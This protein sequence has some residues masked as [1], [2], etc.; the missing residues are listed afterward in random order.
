MDI[1]RAWCGVHLG[2]TPVEASPPGRNSHG[3]CTD[4]SSS[5][6][7][8]TRTPV[9]EFLRGL[10]VPVLLVG[11]NVEVL[12]ANQAAL[13]VLGKAVDAVTGRLGG[14]VFE[15]DN[16]HLPGGCG[17]TIHCTGCVLRRTVTTTY[18][19]GT[20]Q[21]RVPASL[22]VRTGAGPGSVDLLITTARV[23]GRVLVKFETAP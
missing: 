4:C 13:G 21:V 2:A 14:K 5:L 11:D 17:R 10:G 20:P 6:L 23:G 16:A 12:D 19:Q 15:C 7:G 1:Y 22:K 3:I 18:Q 9:E 8:E